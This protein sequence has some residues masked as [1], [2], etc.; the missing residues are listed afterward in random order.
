ML[1]SRGLQPILQSLD[2]KP[3]DI[4]NNFISS[5][6][7]YLQLTPTSIHRRNRTKCSIQKFKDHF[8]AGLCSVYSK[9]PLNLW[10][11]LIPQALLIF[12]LLK[13]N[14]TN[15]LLLAYAQVHETFSY[16]QIPLA[17]SV[18]KVLVHIRPEDRPL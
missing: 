15:P 4:L 10:D 18:I 17:P 13:S 9:F 6:K 5:Q 3:S 8:V 1:K 14:N 11:K 7:V 2:N 12:S 16:N